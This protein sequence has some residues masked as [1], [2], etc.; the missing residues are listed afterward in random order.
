MK[1]RTKFQFENGA[2]DVT[3]HINYIIITIKKPIINYQPL[4]SGIRKLRPSE[5]DVVL[6]TDDRY[7]VI[8]DHSLWIVKPIYIH[9]HP[10]KFDATAYETIARHYNKRRNRLYS[11]YFLAV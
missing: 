7:P 4:F 5:R 6:A 11:L 10:S 1:L 2:K 3:Q 8:T 9:F